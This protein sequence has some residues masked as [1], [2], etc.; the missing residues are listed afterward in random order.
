MSD[1][2]TEAVRDATVVNREGLHARPASRFVDRASTFA[3]AITV[4]NVSRDGELVDGKSAMQM[5]LLEATQG[6]V[7]RVTARGGDAH[8]AAGSLA[9]FI[10]AGFELDPHQNTQQPDHAG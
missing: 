10:E 7:L 9:A 6:C 5:V 3:S 8:E 2:E 1:T 4:Q